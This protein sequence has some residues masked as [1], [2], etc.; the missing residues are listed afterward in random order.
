MKERSPPFG[1]STRL[2]AVAVT[3]P[4]PDSVL[5]LKTATLE[6]SA[7]LKETAEAQQ[8]ANEMMSDEGRTDP[9]AARRTIKECS[10]AIAQLVRVIVLH[11][12]AAFG[13]ATFPILSWARRRHTGMSGVTPHDPNEP[14]PGWYPREGFEADAPE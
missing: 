1:A 7:T 8:A 3:L 6:C 14:R 12:I 11:E 13:E 4:L 10:E 2:G 5:D 9:E